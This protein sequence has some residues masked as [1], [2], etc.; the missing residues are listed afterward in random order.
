[1][2]SACQ[3]YTVIAVF[4]WLSRYLIANLKL[5]EITFGAPETIFFRFYA[6]IQALTVI[7]AFEILKIYHC[8]SE[9][10]LLRYSLPIRNKVAKI[11]H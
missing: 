9:I 11:S 4:L 5:Y 7:V 2:L 10:I 3:A 6:L 8:Q 1:L